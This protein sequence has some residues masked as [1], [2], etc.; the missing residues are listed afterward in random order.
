METIKNMTESRNQI[1]TKSDHSKQILDKFTLKDIPNLDLSEIEDE[2]KNGYKL[3]ARLKI[4]DLD[5][6]IDYESDSEE[7]INVLEKISKNR[8]Q[9]IANI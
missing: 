8:S 6:Q 9:Q 2:V 4:N 7:M 5:R 3:L 1:K